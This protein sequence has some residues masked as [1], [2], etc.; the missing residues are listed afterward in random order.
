MAE[1]TG[2]F[3]AYRQLTPL[4]GSVADDMNYQDQA[5]FQRRAEQRSIQEQEQKKQEAKEKKRADVL[6]KINAQQLYD[7]GSATWNERLHEGLRS[8]YNKWDDIIPILT[9]PEKYSDKEVIKAN[10]VA[11]NLNSFVDQVSAMDKTTREF[12]ESYRKDVAVGKI[13]P[14]PEFEKKFNDSF[15]NKAIG[16]SEDGYAAVYFIDEDGDGLDDNTGKPGK[17]GDFMTYT[18]V[19]NGT[20]L[21]KYTFEDRFNYESVLND[22]SKQI[23]PVENKKPVGNEYVTTI[24]LDENALEER[25]STTLFNQDGTP[26]AILKS[27]AREQGID[28]NNPQQTEAF[29]ESIKEALRLRAKGGEKRELIT[30]PIEWA[31]LNDARA[32]E[33]KNKPQRTNITITEN[34]RDEFAQNV[35]PGKDK[36]YPNAISVTI[37]SNG[38]PFKNIGGASTGLNSGYVTTITKD[39]KTGNLVFIGKA[40]KTKNARFK[41]GTETVDYNKLNE[42]AQNGN[43]EAELKLDQY[44]KGNNYGTFFRVMTEKSAAPIIMQA[45]YGSIEEVKTELDQM[46]QEATPAKPKIKEENKKLGSKYN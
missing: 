11:D 1:A 39:K 32:K 5:G 12:V 4:K 22:L 8:A 18:E 20:G 35:A 44:S 27:F 13:W 14:N 45:G 3:S 26:S 9:N 34:V 24:G 23:K 42:E 40:L 21:T 6:A 31:R 17:V 43:Q 15:N 16:V 36:V 10:L 33:Q 7:T 2:N 25:V 28:V 38:V 29:K 37:G 19:V 41:L 30:D 46:N